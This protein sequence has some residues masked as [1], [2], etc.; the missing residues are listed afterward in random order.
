MAIGVTPGKISPHLLAYIQGAPGTV[1]G[2]IGEGST[3]QMTANWDSPF[4]QDSAGS[5]MERTGGLIQTATGATS[6]GVLQS[7]Q[8]WNGNQPHTFDLTLE[9]FAV[10]DAFSE[11][12]SAIVALEQM[13][14]P[15]VNYAT[16]LGRAPA[17]ASVQIGRSV[18]YPECVIGMVSYDTSGPVD[19]NGYPLRASVQLEI[20]TKAMINGTDIASTFG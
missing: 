7:T 18:I 16:P 1:V 10:S 8:V 3:R 14:A 15:D 19:S 12:Q 4:E 11:V 5:M 17:V 2:V 9:L 6:K 13:A 20:Q